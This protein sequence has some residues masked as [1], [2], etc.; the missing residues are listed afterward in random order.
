MADK[1]DPLIKPHYAMDSMIFHGYDGQN[2]MV[3]FSCHPNHPM[4]PTAVF[5]PRPCEAPMLLKIKII[6]T[7]RQVWHSGIPWNIPWSPWAP[8]W[9]YD[10]WLMTNNHDSFWHGIWMWGTIYCQFLFYCQF[11]SNE[12][13][14]NVDTMWAADYSAEFLWDPI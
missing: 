7:T 6:Q 8:L 4:I 12:T 13:T 14:W 5:Q 3:F 11:L 10:L 2:S 9:G 1:A